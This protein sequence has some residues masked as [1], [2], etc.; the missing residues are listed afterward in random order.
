MSKKSFSP[1][2]GD[3]TACSRAM[4]TMIGF[5]PPYGD[6][7]KRLALQRLENRVFAPLRGW[8]DKTM[9]INMPYVFSPPYGDGTNNAAITA[10]AL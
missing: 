1:P 4:P 2:Y 9:K 5:S 8:Y 10:K 7:T 6:S 3:S